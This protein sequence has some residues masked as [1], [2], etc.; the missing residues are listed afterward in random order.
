MLRAADVEIDRKPLLEKLR[1]GERLV[2]ERIDVTEIVPAAAGPLR[3]RVRLADALLAGLRVG[4][5]HPIR[6]LRERRLASARRLVVLKLGERQRQISLV[7]ER[8]RAVLPV[9]HRERL[10]P[11]ALTRE[12]PVAEL[13][14]RL[15][16]ADLVLL[17]PFDHRLARVVD[18]ESGEEPGRD[19][20]ARRNVRERCVLRV[21]NRIL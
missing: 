13:V 18:R 15:R 21:G 11:V 12:E 16:L 10:A 1:I 5:V 6:R 4:D 2:V 14:L 9:N 7:D 8:L 3:H 20:H 17:Q 19:H